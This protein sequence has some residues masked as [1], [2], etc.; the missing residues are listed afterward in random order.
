LLAAVPALRATPV[1][2]TFGGGPLTISIADDT[3]MQVINTSQQERQ[4]NPKTCALG[5]TADSG[6]LASSGGAVFG[7]DFRNHSCGSAANT[8]V[9]WTAVNIGPVQGAGTT[10]DPFTV[11]VV[12]DAGTTG[13]RLMEALTYVNGSFDFTPTIAFANRGSAPIQWTTFLAADAN[14]GSGNVVRPQVLGRLR[15]IGQKAQELGAPFPACDPKPYYL[16]FPPAERYTGVS[17]PLLWN[18]ISGGSLSNTVQGGCP[19]GGLAVQWETRTLAPGT[20]VTLSAQPMSFVND[21]PPSAD[22]VPTLSLAGNACLLVA[23]AV[24][25]VVLVRRI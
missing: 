1:V 11:V 5:Q 17:V 22:V 6:I 8:Y 4:F 16:M 13:L 7:P 12:A 19:H 2:R 9:P 10:S 24:A 14:L 25:G 3:S 21:F 20:S 18:E 23:L 15:L